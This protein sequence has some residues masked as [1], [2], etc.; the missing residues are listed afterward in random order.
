MCG[1]NATKPLFPVNTLKIEA[2]SDISFGVAGQGGSDESKS[3]APVSQFHCLA[4]SR[5]QF[6]VLI[7]LKWDPNF[8]QYHDGPATAYLSKAPDGVDLNDYE[9]QGEWFKIGA[10]GASDGIH[11]DYGRV[12]TVRKVSS[13]SCSS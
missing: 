11:W 8:K 4:W 13:V 6:H 3:T 12:N 1:F 7:L 5:L 2:G 10:V 9:G